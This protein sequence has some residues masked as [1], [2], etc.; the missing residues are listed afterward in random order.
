[1]MIY[2]LLTHDASE[3]PSESPSDCV[4]AILSDWLGVS[5]S[6]LTRHTSSQKSLQLR[7]SV[8]TLDS[9]LDLVDVLLIAVDYA[10][11]IHSGRCSLTP[12]YTRSHTGYHTLRNIRLFRS[13][14]VVSGHAAVHVVFDTAYPTTCPIAHCLRM[15]SNHPL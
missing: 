5:T 10:R 13:V 9:S 7:A 6:D 1:M 14:C 8:D 12:R 15:A 2:L 3:S 4:F 11:G